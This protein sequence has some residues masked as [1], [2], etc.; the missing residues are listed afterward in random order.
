ME[1]R[2]PWTENEDEAEPMLAEQFDIAM[3]RTQIRTPELI[4]ACRS[5]L[6]ESKKASEVAQARGIDAAHIRRAVTT[7][8]EKWQE[9]CTEQGWE[10]LPVALPRHA[11]KLVLEM[12]REHLEQYREGKSGGRKKKK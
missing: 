1:S 11:M 3:E 8:R 6:V 5:V 2:T 9:I 10:Y 7:I 4:A 12:Q